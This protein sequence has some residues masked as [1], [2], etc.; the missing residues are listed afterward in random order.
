M[1]S[2][3]NYVMNLNNIVIHTPTIGD[4]IGVVEYILECGYRWC[5]MHRAS[6][7]ESLWYEYEED[8]CIE[9]KNDTIYIGDYDY[10]LSYNISINNM[11]DFFRMRFYKYFI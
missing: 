9:V 3:S 4:Y 10:F 5:G 11:V 8:T 2:Y 7:N 1:D 6:V